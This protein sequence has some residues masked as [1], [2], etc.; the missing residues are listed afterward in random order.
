MV[1]RVSRHV[2]KVGGQWV[3]L[4]GGLMGKP[5]YLHGTSSGR[6]RKYSALLP[7]KRKARSGNVYYESR[8]NRADSPGRRGKVRR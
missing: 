8:K 6:D 4:G 5:T 3:F 7:G 1:K 2:R